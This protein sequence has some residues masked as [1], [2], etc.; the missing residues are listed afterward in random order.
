M[1]SVCANP[2]AIAI[3][4]KDVW[5]ANRLSRSSKHGEQFRGEWS[6]VK[7][8]VMNLNAKAWGP[9]ALTRVV[10]LLPA[11]VVALSLTFAGA[12]SAQSFQ[13]SVKGITPRDKACPTTTFCGTASIA[14]H[15]PA[16]RHSRPP[17]RRQ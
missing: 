11:L 7:E 9:G 5:V 17:A 2:D 16:T 6:M 3:D 14:G 15:G 4:G 10:I 13:A 8:D 1:H 12:A